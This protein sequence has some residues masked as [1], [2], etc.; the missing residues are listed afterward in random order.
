MDGFRVN[1]SIFYIFVL[2]SKEC[3]KQ[4]ICCVNKRNKQNIGN[5]CKFE[6]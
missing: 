5:R 6:K 1:S 3:Y 4:Q 2:T